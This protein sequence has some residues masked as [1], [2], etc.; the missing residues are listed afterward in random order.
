M[1]LQDAANLKMFNL[2]VQ[3]TAGSSKG[4]AVKA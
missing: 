3:C 4:Q 1:H 2:R